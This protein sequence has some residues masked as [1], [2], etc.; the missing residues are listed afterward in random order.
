MKP[1]WAATMTVYTDPHALE[2]HRLRLLLEEKEVP[3]RHQSLS[4]NESWPAELLHVNP[5]QVMPFITDKNFLLHGSA[6]LDEYINERYPFPQLLPYE[7]TDRAVARFLVDQLRAAYPEPSLKSWTALTEALW[8]ASPWF[9]GQDFTIVDI[10]AAP[11]LYRNRCMLQTAPDHVR[12]Y[13]KRLFSRPAFK[14]SLF[15]EIELPVCA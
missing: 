3:A 2:S 11:L 7:P 8:S 12:A 5:T 14:R 15:V 6:T 9:L 4:P 10:A 1:F 13:A